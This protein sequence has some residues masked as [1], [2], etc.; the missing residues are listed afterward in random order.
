LE[1]KKGYVNID[2]FDDTVADQMMSVTHLEFDDQSFSDVDCI[3]VLEHLGAA[4]SIY[5][6][7]EIYRVLVKGGSFLLETPDL[8]SSFKSFIKADEDNRKMI[9]NWIYG[10]DIPGMSHK[11]GFPKELLLRMLQET[12]F[13]NIEIVHLKSKS[14]HPSLRATCRKGESK[15]HDVM[16][17]FRKTLIEKE[18]M[19]LEN[20]VEVIEKEALIQ[21]LIQISLNSSPPLKDEQLRKI[22]VTS[23]ACSPKIG[24]VF[25]DCFIDAEL[26]PSNSTRELVDVLEELDSMNFVNILTYI[27]TEMPLLPSQQN[28]TF[29]S[30]VKLGK[31]TVRKFIDKDQSAIDELRSTSKKIQ[32]EGYIDYFSKV[33]LEIMSNR[34]LAL[35]LKAF[36]LGKIEEATDLLHDAVRLNRDSI[37]AFWNL[38]RLSA[39]KQNRE[40]M[41]QYYSTVGKLLMFQ[42]PKNYHNYVS[43][44]EN[45]RR[46]VEL[47]KLKAVSKPIYSY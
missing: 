22:V 47:G 40:E 18:I 21:E 34:K 15:I 25:L 39:L 36:G 28:E 7:S 31:Q 4:K 45:E 43:N 27:F 13:I 10:L 26:A 29:A 33:G 23:S 1:Y 37:I 5:A 6:L 8:V 14:I 24:Q 44:I 30:V 12:G 2:A 46:S 9:M 20:Q 16:S 19:N 42:N 17:Q 11:Y 3:Q 38:A 32:E 35:G 41:N